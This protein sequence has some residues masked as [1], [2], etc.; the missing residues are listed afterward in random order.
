MVR[1]VSLIGLSLLHYFFCYERNFIETIFIIPDSLNPGSV[2]VPYYGFS[3]RGQSILIVY[4]HS[5]ESAFLYLPSCNKFN[6]KQLP[7]GGWLIYPWKD[8]IRVSVEEILK[9]NMVK[10]LIPRSIQTLKTDPLT[11]GETE[12]VVQNSPTKKIPVSG[13]F[14]S[15]SNKQ[16]GKT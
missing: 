1:P 15:G 7:L 6:V 2:I 4:G 11:T 5:S 9:N 13:N 14:T 10:W 3:R 12:P 8:V 16:T